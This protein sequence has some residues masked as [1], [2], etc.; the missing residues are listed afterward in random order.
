M[1]E[2]EIK[3]ISDMYL[4]AALLAY[5]AEIVGIDRSD[6][7]RQQFEFVGCINVIYVL[8]QNNVVKMVNPSIEDIEIKFYSKSLVFPPNYPNA[9]RD[10]KSA[11]HAR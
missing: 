7:K 2:N 9:L 4:A 1:I 8:D 10:I 6:P 3:P 5:G 11:I